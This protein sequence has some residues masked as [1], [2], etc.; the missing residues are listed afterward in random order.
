MSLL[1]KIK[2][3]SQFALIP[4]RASPKA[5]DIALEIPEGH[6]GRIASRSSLALKHLN[7]G[8]GVIDSDY[9]GNLGVILF[10]HGDKPFT[11]SRGD[12]IAQLILEK[13]S[14]PEVFVVGDEESL[15]ETQRGENGFGS[16]G[17]GFLE[18]SNKQI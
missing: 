13:I 12:R 6:Y 8:G 1:L 5:A 10:N 7:V 9:R 15:E 3:L 4:Q 14:T 17:V 16:T 2:K 18:P 11:I